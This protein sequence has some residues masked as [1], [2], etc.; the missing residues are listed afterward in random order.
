MGV[1]DDL[2]RHDD[3]VLVVVAGPRHERRGVPIEHVGE[4][5]AFGELVGRGAGGDRAALV[6][7]PD[8]HRNAFALEPPVVTGAHQP[9]D[10]AGGEQLRDRQRSL[11]GLVEAAE[12]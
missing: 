9:D 10:V 1:R 12:G 6:D 3:R 8:H 7:E 2:H 5:R 4:R 11:L